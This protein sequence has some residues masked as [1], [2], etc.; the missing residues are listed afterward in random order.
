MSLFVGENRTTLPWLV[1]NLFETG[2]VEV[3]I[4]KESFFGLI[5]TELSHRSATNSSDFMQAVQ[6]FKCLERE[7]DEKTQGV[8]LV[9]FKE[10]VTSGSCAQVNRDHLKSRKIDL[11]LVDAEVLPS[12]LKDQDGT[13][14]V[15]AKRKLILD[16]K[17]PINL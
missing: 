3:P 2:S 14:K 12:S 9:F 1:A 11:C 10:A 13:R 16:P 6:V 8:F 15:K 4:E 17:H 5:Q 7:L